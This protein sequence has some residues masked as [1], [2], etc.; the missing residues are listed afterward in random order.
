MTAKGNVVAWMGSRH[1]KGHRV[2]SKEVEE[3]KRAEEQMDVEYVFLHG[4]IRD[5]PSDTEVHAE[6]QLRADRHACPAE[7]NT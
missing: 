7:K 1:T 3:N 6:H 2:K 4:Y 5:R